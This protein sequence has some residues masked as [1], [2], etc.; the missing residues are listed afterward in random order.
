MKQQSGVLSSSGKTKTPRNQTQSKLNTQIIMP[1]SV[2]TYSVRHG[3]SSLDGNQSVK[4]GDMINS[5]QT[6]VSA[7]KKRCNLNLDSMSPSLLQSLTNNC[8]WNEFHYFDKSNS[9]L[10]SD[11]Q[12]LLERG[13][14]SLELQ[15]CLNRSCKLLFF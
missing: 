11:L 1:G 3:R 6:F 14:T 8:R 13:H 2:S 7:L 15:R 5:L 9:Y 10:D 12:H 4:K